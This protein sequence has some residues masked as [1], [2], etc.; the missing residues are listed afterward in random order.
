MLVYLQIVRWQIH[1]MKKRIKYLI[2]IFCLFAFCNITYHSLK[3]A[4][5]KKDCST[6]IDLAIQVD[7][8]YR[9]EPSDANRNKYI[10][11]LK[12]LVVAYS[13]LRDFE[14]GNKKYNIK[15]LVDYSSSSYDILEVDK[16]RVYQLS[17]LRHGLRFLKS[18]LY[19]ES[20]SASDSFLTFIKAN[21]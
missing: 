19:D 4:S 10:M 13:K 1:N 21:S 20:G 11:E 12:K 9:N 3:S 6:H 8:K 7:E 17:D 15:L 16:D 5:L 14:K 2:I 18:D